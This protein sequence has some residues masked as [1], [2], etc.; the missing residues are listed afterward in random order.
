MVG[1]RIQ[2][3]AELEKMFRRM[4]MRRFGYKKG[5]ISKAAEEAIRNWLSVQLQLEKREFEGDPVKAIIGL[6]S[7]IKIDSV[8]LQHLANKIWVKKVLSHVSR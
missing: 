2:L 5:A 6:L 8:K 4:A 3:P 1:I 7:D